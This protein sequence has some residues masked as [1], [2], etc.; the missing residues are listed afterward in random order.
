[1][2]Y[3]WGE[4]LGKIVEGSFPV[5]SKDSFTL[6]A[7]SEDSARKTELLRVDL[8]SQRNG[9]NTPNYHLTWSSTVPPLEAYLGIL[10]FYDE[11]R[12]GEF[13][14]AGN[15]AISAPGGSCFNLD[16]LYTHSRT[17]VERVSRP[18]FKHL[19]L[20]IE[21]RPLDV[22]DDSS[23][24]LEDDV[25]CDEDDQMSSRVGYIS[26][27]LKRVAA[28]PSFSFEVTTSEDLSRQLLPLMHRTLGTVERF[29]DMFLNWH[30][31]KRPIQR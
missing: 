5:I 9:L 18:Q 2:A 12:K 14:L 13:T 22:K 26:L 7:L 23:V 10:S 6:S 24:D 15:A 21:Y 30:S 29:D 11:V 19:F 16:R 17:I 27:M 31:Y 28:N 1:M 25:V 3:V 20:D 4:E 8:L